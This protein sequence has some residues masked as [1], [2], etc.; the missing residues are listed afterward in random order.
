MLD[1][2]K[3]RLMTKLAFYEETLGK[4]D[5]KVDEYYRNDYVGFHII[6]SIMWTTIGYACVV[7]LAALAG[8]DWILNNISRSVIIMMIVAVVVGY[9]VVLVIY[10]M[11]SRYIFKRK[12][13]RARQR[14]KVFNHNLNILL[15]L[16]EKEKR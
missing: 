10:S 1:K 4:E 2:E 6:C 12:H 9:L 5:F 3:V 15:K 11:I 8:M 7:G 16:Y 14:V 13:N